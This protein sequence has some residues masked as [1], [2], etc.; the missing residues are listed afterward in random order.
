MD[1]MALL[2]A[3]ASDAAI[4]ANGLRALHVHHGMQASADDWTRHCEAACRELCIALVVERVT[5]EAN[6]LGREGAARAARHAA[7]ERHLVYGEHLAAAHHR[8]DQAETFLLRA[9]RASGVDGLGAMTPLRPL[10]RGWLWRPWLDVPRDAI[11]AFARDRGIAWVDDPSNIDASIDRVFLR[12]HVLPLLRTRWP[13]ADAA[14]AGAAALAREASSLLTDDD[15]RL[16]AG[17]VVDRPDVLSIPS[18]TACPPARRTRL[19]RAWIASLDLPPLTARA[20]DRVERELLDAR[21]DSDACVDWHDAR[22]RAWGGLLHA[23]RPCPP[24]PHDFD[25][26]WTGQETLALPDGGELRFDPFLVAPADFR[27]RARIGGERIRL[28]GRAHH[29]ALK[30]VLQDER[31]PPWTR[32]HLPVLLAHD[33]EVLA[34]GDIVL[35]ARMAE[36]LRETGGR[37]VWS[38]PPGA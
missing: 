32:E 13:H 9:L 8:D 17:C 37:L 25:I 35:G 6:G 23:S 19:L 7:F 27:V 31:V 4:R 36:L 38:C 16:L 3:L 34:A 21:A 20:A 26:G 29:H 18:L 12:Q 1:S 30:H 10:G 15:R 24:L 22:I 14:L 33:D 2:H 28:P 11:A 5:V